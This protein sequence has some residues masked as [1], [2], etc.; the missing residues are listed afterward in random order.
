MQYLKKFNESL[1]GDFPT[2]PD[3]IIEICRILDI[4]PSKIHPDGTVDIDG[5]LDLTTD[6]RYYFDNERNPIFKRGRLPLKFGDV[7]GNCYIN[8][9]LLT[10]LEGSP[11]TVGG[12][13]FAGANNFTDLKGGPKEVLGDYNINNCTRLTS[14]EGIPQIIH[15]RLNVYGSHYLWDLR[16]LR[17]VNVL[18]PH[19]INN[20]SQIGPVSFCLV[21]LFADTWVNHYDKFIDSLVYNYIRDPIPFFTQRGSDIG[22]GQCFVLNLFRLKEA[23]EDA[24]IS[25][26]EFG[27]EYPDK[28]YS[29]Y[30]MND[31]GRRVNFQGGP[32]P[33]PW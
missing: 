19:L 30:Y 28:Y 3:K 7:G 8:N 17:D 22:K 32:I 13:F 18:Q 4:K 26:E 21:Q 2:D 20:S 9:C 27:S 33:S 25:L 14:L 31:E 15:T 11:N 12:D 1:E 24:E 5:G 23:M 16:P 6:I 29:W 10:T